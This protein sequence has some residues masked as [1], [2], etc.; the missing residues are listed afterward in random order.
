METL[1]L[2]DELKDEPRTGWDAESI[3]HALAAGKTLYVDG[4][5]DVW[6]EGAR[7]YAG[8]IKSECPD[9]TATVGHSGN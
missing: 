1:R 8:R 4:N 3:G 2:Y 5:G 6:T 7:E 9:T